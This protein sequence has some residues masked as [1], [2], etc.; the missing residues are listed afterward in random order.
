[1]TTPELLKIYEKDVK[2]LELIII[3]ESIIESNLETIERMKEICTDTAN[4]MKKSVERRR[5]MVERLKKQLKL[6]I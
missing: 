5:G 2:T 3:Q 4:E 1:M 6:K